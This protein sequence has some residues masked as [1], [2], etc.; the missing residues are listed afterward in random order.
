MPYIKQLGSALCLLSISCVCHQRAVSYV[1]VSSVV[2]TVK[3]GSV[4]GVRDFR[5]S[6]VDNVV[7]QS[8]SRDLIPTAV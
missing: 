8:G 7:I 2:S 4:P 6:S 3:T 1:V 5:P